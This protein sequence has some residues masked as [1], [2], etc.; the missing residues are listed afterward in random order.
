MTAAA[1]NTQPY[2]NTEII[3]NTPSNPQFIYYS[4]KVVSRNH[5]LLKHENGKFY[6]KDT[7]SSSGTFL[8]GKRLSPQGQES[9]FFELNNGDIVKLGEDCQVNKSTKKKLILLL[10]INI[11]Y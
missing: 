11:K 7:G 5:A 2:N 10:Y 4:S 3:A 9:N 8:N 1:S 6:I